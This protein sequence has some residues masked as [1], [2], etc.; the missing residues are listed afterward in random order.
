VKH[1][2]SFLYNR[3]WFL[4]TLPRSQKSRKQLSSASLQRFCI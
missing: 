2:T 3:L 4:S 1:S